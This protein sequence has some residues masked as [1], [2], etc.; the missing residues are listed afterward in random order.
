M[1][2]DNLMR[3]V[4]YARYSSDQQRDASIDVKSRPT[5]AL[6]QSW[7]NQGGRWSAF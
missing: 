7:C 1:A 2:G 6:T 5:S 4:I 3:V